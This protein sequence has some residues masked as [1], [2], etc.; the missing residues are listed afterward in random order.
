MLS[1]GTGRHGCDL[2]YWGREEHLNL[3][4]LFSAGSHGVPLGGYGLYGG[5]H[6][7]SGAA[8]EEGSRH[9]SAQLGCLGSQGQIFQS[10]VSWGIIKTWSYFGALTLLGSCPPTPSREK[11]E[12]RQAPVFWVHSSISTCNNHSLQA[13]KEP[14]KEALGSGQ[15]NLLPGVPSSAQCLQNS[16]SAEPVPAQ[17]LGVHLAFC[18]PSTA[19]EAGGRKPEG[20]VPGRREGSRRMP[21]AGHPAPA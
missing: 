20:G 4:Q 12:A 3:L 17:I 7:A 6:N 15:G 13:G 21:H 1:G 19:N 2:Q 10:L 11:P 18:V 8:I 16:A 9:I 5:W 14:R